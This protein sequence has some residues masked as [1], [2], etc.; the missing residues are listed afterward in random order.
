MVRR[1]APA[2][3]PAGS[4]RPLGGVAVWFFIVDLRETVLGNFAWYLIRAGNLLAAALTETYLW[5]S[6]PALK[7]R[8]VSALEGTPD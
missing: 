5:R 2:D 3:T 6:H 7:H 8:L 4:G 1:G